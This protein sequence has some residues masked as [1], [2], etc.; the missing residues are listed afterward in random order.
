MGATQKTETSRPFRP[1][2]PP[3]DGS[4]V[5]VAVSIERGREPTEVTV[6]RVRSVAHVT[7]SETQVAEQP[8]PEVV[9]PSSQLSPRAAWT[10]PSPHNS[11]LQVAEQPSPEVVLPSSHCSVP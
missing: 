4:R 8:S 7:A 3:Q 5:A 11:D 9:L 6:P 10:T 2:V 1:P